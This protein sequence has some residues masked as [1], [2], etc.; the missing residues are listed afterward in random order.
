MENFQTEVNVPPGMRIQ[1]QL[2]YHEMIR[3]KLSSYEHVISVKPGRLAK[4]MEVKQSWGVEAE[5]HGE[6]LLRKLQFSGRCLCPWQVTWNW[7]NFRIPYNPNH[8]GILR[9]NHGCGGTA[10]DHQLS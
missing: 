2:H 4:H 10:R 9:A 1:F 8:S 7:I 5:L 6:S 3:R